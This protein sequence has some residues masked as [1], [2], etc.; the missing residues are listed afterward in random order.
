MGSIDSSE[1]YVKIRKT[2]VWI[3]Y[4]QMRNIWNSKLS[5]KFKIRLMISCNIAT[6]ESVLLY[7]CETWTLTNS[8]LK[9]MDGTNTQ[10]LR[11]VLNIHWTNK[12]KNETLYGTIERLSNT[13]RRRRLKFAGHCLRREDEVVSDLVMWQPTH[14]TRRRGR[15]PDSYIK[16]LERDTGLR[17]NYLL[18]LYLYLMNR[19]IWKSIIV[20]K[21]IKR[22]PK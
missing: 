20:L 14:G 18:Q 12:I 17:E 9:K 6:V 22:I 5:R 1:K 3:T 19:N 21:S 7:G 13:I 16:T 4:H 8:L 10:I 15:P 2:Q 11:M